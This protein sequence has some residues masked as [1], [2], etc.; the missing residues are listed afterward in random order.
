MLASAPA[1]RETEVEEGFL[2]L[3]TELLN[4]TDFTFKPTTTEG[5]FVV[6]PK[7]SEE[8]AFWCFVNVKKGEGIVSQMYHP[9]GEEKASEV[10]SGVYSVVNSCVHR[11]NQKLLLK[12]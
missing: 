5:G 2:L 6:F 11:V 10:M 4:T 12:R 7:E 8:L 1:G 9:G 3:N